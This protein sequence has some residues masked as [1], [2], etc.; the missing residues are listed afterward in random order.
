M[1]AEK[2]LEEY[3]PE[4]VRQA[5][6]LAMDSSDCHDELVRQIL[7]FLYSEKT[8][9][10]KYIEAGLMVITDGFDDTTIDIPL[11]PRLLGE[12]VG[13]LCLAG[14]TD[15][16]VLKDIMVKMEDKPRKREIFDLALCIIK[17]SPLAGAL[18]AQSDDLIEC[19][20][21]IS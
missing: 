11:A 9:P 7:E 4:F 2:N 20:N 12:L 1:E 8:L 21:L 17:S 13:R 15:F 3:Y 10:D 19:E 16:R 18:G 5:I 14:A 6:M